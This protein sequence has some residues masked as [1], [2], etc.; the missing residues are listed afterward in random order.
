MSPHGKKQGFQM[1]N[2]LIWELVDVMNWNNQSK[3]PVWNARNH[4]S[5]IAPKN[6]IY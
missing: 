3:E 5:E 2:Q 4:Y 6:I 1:E